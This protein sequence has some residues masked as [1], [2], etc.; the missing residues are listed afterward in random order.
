MPMTY[1]SLQTQVADY[2]DRTDDDTLAQIPNFIE[3]AQH[4]ICRESKS[5]GLESYVQGNFVAGQATYQ[6]PSLWRRNITL[7]FNNSVLPNQN[8]QPI[9]LKS[10]EYVRLYWPNQAATAPPV[11]YCDYGYYNFLV[12]PTPD[13]D[14]EYELGYLQL[15]PLLSESNQTNWLTDYAPD[16]LL[17]STL[18]ESAPYLKTDDRL[19]VWMQLYQAGLQSLNSQDDARITDRGSN[20]TAD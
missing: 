9:D 13:Q 16:V 3:Q 4:R 20:R 12:A 11:Y 5:V 15:P 2:L 7:T 14:Y 10:Y 18:I 19:Q 8:N 17:Y 6:K 1:D